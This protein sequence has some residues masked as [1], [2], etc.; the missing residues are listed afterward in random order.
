MT[1][2]NRQSSLISIFSTS[3]KIKTQESDV[4]VFASAGRE[5]ETR[6]FAATKG[7]STSTSTT[8]L[9]CSLTIRRDRIVRIGLLGVHH[10][11]LRTSVDFGIT[12]WGGHTRLGVLCSIRP[13]DE[14]RGGLWNTIIHCVRRLRAWDRLWLVMERRHGW[15]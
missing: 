15:H 8:I 14:R 2:G 6:R 9:R 13:H 10:G 5:E 7:W 1:C 11:R 3:Y 12:D 4:P